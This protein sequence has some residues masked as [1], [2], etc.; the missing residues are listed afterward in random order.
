MQID[1][2]EIVA[3]LR[4]RGEQDRADWVERTLPP[5]VDTDRNSSLLSM[6]SIDLTTLTAVGPAAQHV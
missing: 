1:R 5:V 4:A 3:A 2:G 6:L